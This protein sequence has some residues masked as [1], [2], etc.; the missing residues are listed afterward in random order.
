MADTPIT[1]LPG[2]PYFYAIP[3]NGYIRD[4]PDSRSKRFSKSCLQ[5]RHSSPPQYNPPPPWSPRM[6]E[7]LAELDGMNEIKAHPGYRQPSDR[8]QI[9]R[10]Q[11]SPP[12]MVQRRRSRVPL[13]S[14]RQT[15][16]SHKPR[17]PSPLSSTS[18]AG[19]FQDLFTI[20]E[21]EPVRSIDRRRMDWESRDETRSEDDMSEEEKIQ[22][23]LIESIF[24]MLH[25]LQPT[26]IP[27]PRPSR[28][29]RLLRTPTIRVSPLFPV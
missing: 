26:Y 21:N 2:Y 19:N 20:E 25:Q 10:P 7:G 8:Q 15:W 17:T 16:T 23:V 29:A 3:I 14:T 18:S 13:I 11:T 12:E 28:K 27:Q 22:M 9:K 5:D 4:G 24:S 6:V 1:A